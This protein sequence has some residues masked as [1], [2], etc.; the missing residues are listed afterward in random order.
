MNLHAIRAIYA[1]AA[2]ITK[3]TGV[4]HEVDHFYPLQGEFVCGLHCEANLQILTKVENIRKLNRMP[5]EHHEARRNLSARSGHGAGGTGV[6][7]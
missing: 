5:E 7:L 6:R 4:R 3:E 1:E 2:R